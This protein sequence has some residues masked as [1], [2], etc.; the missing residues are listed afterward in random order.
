VADFTKI[1]EKKFAKVLDKRNLRVVSYSQQA[2]N[3]PDRKA[4]AK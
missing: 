4:H 1:V 3:A 2:E